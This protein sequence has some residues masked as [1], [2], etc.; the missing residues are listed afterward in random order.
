MIG[1]KKIG[2]AAFKVSFLAILG[3]FEGCWPN[4]FFTNHNHLVNKKVPANFSH[5]E[6]YKGEYSG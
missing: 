4:F 3:L 2:P 1:E 6:R 5:F